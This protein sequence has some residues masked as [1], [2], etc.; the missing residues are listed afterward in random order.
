MKR[1]LI[2]YALITC[3]SC[4]GAQSKAQVKP[5]ETLIHS[6]IIEYRRNG[7]LRK[8]IFYLMKEP[9]PGALSTR[10]DIIAYSKIYPKDT[11]NFD[12]RLL[13][14]YSYYRERLGY[15]DLLFDLMIRY[16]RNYGAKKL[17]WM[18]SPFHLKSGESREKMLLNLI[19]FYEKKGGKVTK[20]YPGVAADMEFNVATLGAARQSWL[21]KSPTLV[22][23]NNVAIKVIE[24]DADTSYKKLEEAETLALVSKESFIIINQQA[25]SLFQQAKEYIKAKL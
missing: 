10:D 4:H 20:L 8:T 24:V 12:L 25:Q 7:K 6:K 17:Y 23:K 19:R 21:P 13:E 3:I 2:A 14:V 1:F 5:E 9:Q 22:P 16:L 15:G 11:N 18:A